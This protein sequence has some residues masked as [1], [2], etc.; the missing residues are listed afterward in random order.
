MSVVLKTPKKV[1][2]K[3][4][5]KSFLNII[6]RKFKFYIQNVCSYYGI[7][8]PQVTSKCHNSVAAIYLQN[9]NPRWR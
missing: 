2:Y 4:N 8:I 9:K 1:I 7:I 6:S 5:S 3:L